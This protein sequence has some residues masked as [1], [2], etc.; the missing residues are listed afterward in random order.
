MGY[1]SAMDGDAFTAYVRDVL[2]PE[3]TPRTVV[4]YDNLATHYNKAAAQA[5][6]DAGCWFL[7]LP[8]YSP[9][10]NPI[11]MA[12]SKLKAPLRRVGARSFDQIVRSPGRNLRPIHTAGMLELLL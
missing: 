5:L 6:K 4:M 7:Y 9:D 11:E 2:V 3:L 8:P 10:L 1:Q 12:F